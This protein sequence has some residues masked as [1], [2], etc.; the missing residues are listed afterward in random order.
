MPSISIS[1]LTVK[2]QAEGGGG[3]NSVGTEDTVLLHWVLKLTLLDLTT[4]SLELVALHIVP[5]Q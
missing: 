4:T 5:E 1:F 3:E 2:E